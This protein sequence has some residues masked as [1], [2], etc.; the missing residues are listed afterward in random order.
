MIAM[1]MICEPKLL[2][3]DEPTTALDV[4]VQAQILQLLR[5]IHE[6]THTSVLFISHDLNVV[7][8]ICHRVLVMYQGQIVEQGPVSQVFYHPRHEYTKQLIASVPNRAEGLPEPEKIL[9]IKDLNVF[10]EERSLPFSQKKKQH[11]L[12]NI[13]L[14]IYRGK[15]LALWEKAGAV[16][17]L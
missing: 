2:I 14:D 5:K 15:S 3:A 8:E 7:K 11:V 10:Y 1:A 17:Q 13:S 6:K 9:E 12:K 16:N 4:T